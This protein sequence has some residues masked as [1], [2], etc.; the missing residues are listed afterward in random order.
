MPAPGNALGV[1][2]VFGQIGENEMRVIQEFGPSLIFLM[3]DHEAETFILQTNQLPYC[4]R[5]QEHV[6]Q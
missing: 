6:R 1:G 4:C 3:V 2:L 5:N